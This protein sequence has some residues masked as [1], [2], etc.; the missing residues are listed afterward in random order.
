MNNCESNKKYILIVGASSG[1]GAAIAERLSN[2][3]NVI[4]LMARNEDRLISVKNRLR[5]ESEIIKCDVT[6]YNALEL[7]FDKLK[8]KNIK[9]SAM[10]YTAGIC[11]IKPIK[12]MSAGELDEL[13]KIN[14]FGFYEMCRQFQSSKISE[15]GAS[16]VAISSYA[17]VTEEPGMSAYAMSKSAM[18]TA[19][20]VMAKE[21]SK[22]QLRVNAILPSNTESKMGQEL[23]VWTEEELEEI[24]NV[25]FLGAIPK[26]EIAETVAFLISKNSAH[27][28][29]ALIEISAGYG[30]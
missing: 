3:D 6:D 27:I 4:I 25:Q 28:T 21:F 29:G 24:Q 22:R 20:K 18:N 13:F 11:F 15:K 10:V 9:L 14:V 1:I 17:S 12:A 30:M 23:D 26:G 19:V 5:G 2:E 8:Q 16:I 7:F